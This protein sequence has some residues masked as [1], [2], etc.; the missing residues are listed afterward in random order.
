MPEDLCKTRNISGY[1]FINRLRSSAFRVPLVFFFLSTFCLY[2]SFAQNIEPARFDFEIENMTLPEAL[3]HLLHDYQINIA[4]N[5]TDLNTENKLTYQATNKSAEEILTDLLAKSGYQFHVVGNQYVIVKNENKISHG[6]VLQVSVTNKPVIRHDTV[7]VF[8]K[9]MVN[10][11]VFLVDT[12]TMMDTLLVHDTVFVYPKEPAKKSMEKIRPL[13]PDLFDPEGRRNNGLALDIEYGQLLSLF[14]YKPENDSSTRMS[15]L[16]TDA[17]KPS[18]RSYTFGMNLIINKSRLSFKTGLAFTEIQHSFNYE[19]IIKS[20]GN[21]QIDTL[22][23]YYTVGGADTSWYYVTDSSWVPLSLQQYQ[24]RDINQFGYL[25]LKLAASYNFVKGPVYKL[26]VQAGVGLGML[27]YKRGTA[28]GTGPDYKAIPINDLEVQ[29]FRFSWTLGLVGRFRLS[30]TFD[31]I[32][33]INYIN[34]PG[35]VY[36][37]YPVNVQL[38]VV[39]FKLGLMYYL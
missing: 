21:Y 20:G 10:D 26:Y 7:V 35:S 1:C 30:D 17:D 39:S 6:E 5:A 33:E 12:I 16:W 11:T 18:L 24:Y 25:E 31:L 27:V 4:F 29:N 14:A 15:D 38:Q 19:R 13:R 36:K 23:T 8:D 9:I 34:Y 22:D 28:I 2:G 3:E 32:P 37:N